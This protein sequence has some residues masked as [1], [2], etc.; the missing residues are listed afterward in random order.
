MMPASVTLRGS[1]MTVR[2]GV[3]IIGFAIV[4]GGFQNCSQVGFANSPGNGAA[5]QQ[6]LTALPDGPGTGMG[7]T[8]TPN[9]GIG[10]IS[11]TQPTV[12]TGTSSNG[13]V[14]TGTMSNGTVGTG[15]VSN[16]EP[17]VGTGTTSN[18]SNNPLCAN[19]PAVMGNGNSHH[20]MNVN[21]CNEYVACILDAP[22][23]SLK[24]GLIT[25][26]LGGVNA[27]AQSIC[28]TAGEC[29]G[30]V[31]KYFKVKEADFRGYCG[32]NP[33]VLELDNMQVDKLLMN[34]KPL[35]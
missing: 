7:T 14:G 27:V 15:T 33:N 25:Q 5:S 30:P 2:S 28:I 17:M 26:Q 12:G 22:G 32:H 6:S 23:D 18:P 9:T 34:L 3:S 13:T 29:L 31:T 4:L 35:P 11:N 1:T 24:L 10:T 21:V 20:Y 19:I 16:N 8:S